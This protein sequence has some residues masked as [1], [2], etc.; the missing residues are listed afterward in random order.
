M[1]R[2][3][4]CIVTNN[5]YLKIFLKDK[6]FPKKK[7]PFLNYPPGID[8][9]IGDITVLAALLKFYLVKFES[10]PYLTLPYLKCCMK[11]N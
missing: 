4:L 5:K 9:L 1:T 2:A 10:K 3:S 11:L 7:N 8:V 6:K